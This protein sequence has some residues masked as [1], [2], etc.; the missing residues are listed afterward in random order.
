MNWPK[1]ARRN[2]LVPFYQENVD[3][4]R[5][6]KVV[7]GGNSGVTPGLVDISVPEYPEPFGVKRDGK[8]IPS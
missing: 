5:T 3:E 6:G 4:R 8:T 1:G 7:G 2:N